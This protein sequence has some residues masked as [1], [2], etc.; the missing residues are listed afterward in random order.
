MLSP[1]RK[2]RMGVH[3]QI[4]VI[5]PRMRAC[6]C[7]PQSPFH[8]RGHGVK[9]QTPPFGRAWIIRLRLR[10]TR[11]PRSMARGRLSRAGL[12]NWRDP[13]DRGR[14]VHRRAPLHYHHRPTALPPYRPTALPPYRLISRSDT[15][16]PPAPHTLRRSP[17]ASPIGW[18]RWR[19]SSGGDTSAPALRHGALPAPTRSG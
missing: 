16:A 1:A 19:S 3:A 17:P 8:L 6:W 12:L 5:S 15:S 9:K 14:S 11:P 4:I 13:P 18:L 7:P 10:R 2:G